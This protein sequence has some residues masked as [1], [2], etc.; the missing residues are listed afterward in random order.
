MEGGEFLASGSYGCA[1]KMPVRCSD[2]QDKQEKY[3]F[4]GVGKLFGHHRNAND[5]YQKYLQVKKMD[6]GH[7]WSL[8]LLHA[9][10]VVSFEM[11]DK[12]KLCEHVEKQGSTDHS[13]MQLI[14]K[15]GGTDLSSW[16][17]QYKKKSNASKRRIFVSLITKHL[18][19]VIEGLTKISQS[20][21]VHLDIKPPNILFD[22]KQLYIIDFGLLTEQSKLYV[23]KNKSLLSYQYPYYPPEF[24][25]YS[26]RKPLSLKSFQTSVLD[27]MKHRPQTPEETETMN[28]Q[29]ARFYK[30]I[31]SK[32]PRMDKAFLSDELKSMTDRVDIY[33]LGIS[34]WYIYRQM[35][36]KDDETTLKIKTLI[37]KMRNANPYER[38]TLDELKVEFDSF[39][40][41]SV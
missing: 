24:K 1:F 22:K 5:E 17:K 39:R 31:K 29:L 4:Q 15:D 36:I 9:C 34:L 20:G 30:V 40:N 21:Y 7:E 3:Y 41:Y 2:D 12:A 35:I 25:L 23:T 11:K 18:G 26:L 13:Y 32:C 38:I 28:K 37:D 10:S 33:S 16:V 14:Y 19:T 6:P 8:P 27:N